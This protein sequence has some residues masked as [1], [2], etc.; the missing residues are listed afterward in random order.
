AACSNGGQME[1]AVG[2]GEDWSTNKATMI[3]A[4]SPGGGSDLMARTVAQGIEEIDE[5]I[6]ITVENHPGGSTAV[7][8]SHLLS[9]TGNPEFLVGAETTL[10]ALPLAIDTAYRWDDF[11][12]IAQIAEDAL[13][14]AVLANSDYESLDDLA[15][16]AREG[17]KLRAGIVAAV[18]PDSVLLDLLS[19]DQGVEYEPV[20]FEA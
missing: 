18:G 20:V 17:E 3:V 16:T 13:I 10:S 11:T 7:G 8:Y 2:E 1:A 4:A 5:N 14:V 15:E 6:T 9:K 12:P 19:K